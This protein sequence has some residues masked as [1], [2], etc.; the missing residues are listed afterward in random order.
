MLPKAVLDFSNEN[1]ITYRKIVARIEHAIRGGEFRTGE[2]LPTQRELAHL[3]GTTVATVSRAYT[4]L[5]DRGLIKSEVGRG[6]YVTGWYG[7]YTD[8]IGANGR[9][10]YIDLTINRPP[11]IGYVDHLRAILGS[12]AKRVDLSELMSHQPSA[13]MAEHRVAGASWI[14]GLGLNAE[15][16]GVIITN[17]VQH[18]LMVVLAA[19]CQPGD[20]VVV[21]ELSYPGLRLAARTQHLN[22]V[23]CRLDEEGMDPNHLDDLCRKL[24]PAMVVVNPT[25]QNPTCSTMP[26]NR[27]KRIVETV[28]RHGI[29]LIENDIHG[30]MPEKRP[31]T[32]ASLYPN[33]CYYLT[34][35]SKC[36]GTGLRTG[37]ILAP[38][39][40]VSRICSHIRATTW[41]PSVMMAEIM[42]CWINDGTAM[43]IIAWN[44]SESARR[45]ALA[46]EILGSFEIMTDPSAYH[47]WLKL[48]PWWKQQRFVARMIE[49]GVRVTP[50]DSFYVGEFAA[51]EAVRISLGNTD[52][53]ES[54]MRGLERTAFVLQERSVEVIS[55]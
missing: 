28:A 25:V 6:T 47:I 23:G 45:Q 50:S 27:R 52:D 11:T 2:R 53:L 34:G 37:F 7:E 19:F 4:Q 46:R 38:S 33:A 16:P 10:A 5:Q 36:I 22:L 29:R 12:L 15:P 17:G 35:S 8:R 14:S 39:D 42:C 3:I 51:P 54:I 1:R 32:L 41:M 20:T 55:A 44:R 9:P 31:G 18:G 40:D 30:F 21:E 13:G 49:V 26:A 48:P 24:K 43:Q